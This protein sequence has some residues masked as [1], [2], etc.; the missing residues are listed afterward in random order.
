VVGDYELP[1]RCLGGETHRRTQ[2]NAEVSHTVQ[3]GSNSA[4][5]I[6]EINRRLYSEDFISIPPPC[7]MFRRTQGSRL[8]A[9]SGPQLPPPPFF[10]LELELIQ[11]HM[12]QKP[13]LRVEVGARALRVRSVSREEAWASAAVQDTWVSGRGCEAG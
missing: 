6:A 3:Y 7:Y 8:K 5:A 13:A 11:S 1:Q 2:F 10:S 9:E 4:M 12:A